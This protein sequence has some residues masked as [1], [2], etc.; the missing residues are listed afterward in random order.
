MW[1]TT[2]LNPSYFRFSH[3]EPE[4]TILESGRDFSHALN[5]PIL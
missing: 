5:K 1:E 4:P 2:T 3:H